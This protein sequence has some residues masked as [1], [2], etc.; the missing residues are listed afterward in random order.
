ME[1]AQFREEIKEFNDWLRESE[2][3]DWGAVLSEGGHFALDVLGLIPGFGEAADG[4]NCAWYGGEASSGKTDAVGDAALSCAAAAPALGYGASAVKF[5]KWGDKAT[6]FFK[7]LF[8]KGS[9]ALKKC[10]SFTPQTPVLLADGRTKPIKDIKV[11]DSVLATDPVT[12][13]TASR[14]VDRLFSHGGQQSLVTVTVDSDGAD[15][16]AVGTFTATAAHPVWLANRSA[17]VDAGNI[18]PGDR[19]RTP[20][21]TTT[22]V[23]SVQ[24]QSRVQQVFNLSVRDIHTY[25]VLA[26][27]TPILVHNATCPVTFANLGND[28]FVS[29]AGLVYGPDRKHG[30]KLNHVLE[31]M[32][33]KPDRVTHTVFAGKME[34]DELYTLIDEAWAMRAK[35][36]RYPNDAFAFVIP[37]NKII[38]TKGEMYMRIAADPQ[39]NLLL[40]AY[41]VASP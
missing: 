38:G 20:E 25:Y 5:G 21:G 11:G 14:P 19:V 18:V 35:A 26:G 7:S 40:S 17:W 6:G 1:K 39:T 29:P 3:I 41:P 4:A 12:A 37:M 30:H 32:I 2:E 13:E 28:H 27:Q 36:T 9:K 33:E 31:H 23:V 16:D 34:P 10:N 22:E 24:E 8:S 15:G